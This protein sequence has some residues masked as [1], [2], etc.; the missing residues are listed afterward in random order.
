MRPSKG[1]KALMLPKALRD[2]EDGFTLLEVI[3]A[4]SLLM[5]GLLAV[6]SMQVGAINGNADANR[7]TEATTLVQDRMEELMARSYANVTSGSETVG[8]YAITWTV[9][10]NTSGPAKDTKI[11][12]V[13]IS[14]G[15]LKNDIEFM[16]VKPNM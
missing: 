11:V 10:E 8:Q 16:S 1:R 14:E 4:I 9:T 5:V 2:G 13:K 12:N 3:I 7:M 15:G 6:A